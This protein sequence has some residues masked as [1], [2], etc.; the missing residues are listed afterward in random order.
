[1]AGREDVLYDESSY[2]DIAL[3]GLVAG[4]ASGKEIATAMNAGTYSVVCGGYLT[5]ED[6]RTAA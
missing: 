4:G 3:M 6:L 1:M 2:V 5:Q